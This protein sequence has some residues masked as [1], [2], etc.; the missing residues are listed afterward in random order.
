MNTVALNTIPRA[1][2]FVRRV[3][4][5]IRAHYKLPD[6]VDNYP[7]AYVVNFDPSDQPGT[8]WIAF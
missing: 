3:F 6:W 4:G 1:D 5:G 7:K 8:H 2:V